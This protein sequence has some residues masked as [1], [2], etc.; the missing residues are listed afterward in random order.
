MGEEEAGGAASRSP[1][2]SVTLDALP[3]ASFACLLDPF[4]VG[5]LRRLAREDRA[6]RRRLGAAWGRAEVA[7]ARRG[8]LA[9][10]TDLR[11]VVLIFARVLRGEGSPRPSVETVYKARQLMRTAVAAAGT[12]EVSGARYD[13]ELLRTQ[14]AS[15]REGGGSAGMSRARVS[16]ALGIVDGAIEARAVRRGE[17]VPVGVLR[18]PPRPAPPRPARRSVPLRVCEALIRTAR[19]AERV[20]LAL[21]LGV[22]LL[23][24]EIARLRREDVR[25]VRASPGLARAVGCR[26]GTPVVWVRA[27]APGRAARWM[28]AP[29]WV[30]RLMQAAPLGAVGS[31]LVASASAPTLA[32]TIRRLRDVVPGAAGLRASDLCRTW[33][34]VALRLGMRREVVRRTW[35]PDAGGHL[36]RRPA[37]RSARDR[38]D[39]PAL[40]D[41]PRLRD[42]RAPAPRGGRSSA[43]AVQVPARSPRAGSSVPQARDRSASGGGAGLREG[44]RAERVRALEQSSARYALGLRPSDRLGTPL[45]R[46]LFSEP[47]PHAYHQP[48]CR[49]PSPAPPRERRARV[50][51]RP[52][53]KTI[54]VAA[55]W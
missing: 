23:P 48:G 29:A 32:A 1:L 10:T 45:L 26:R 24:G 37:S 12:M 47:A 21:A 8:A 54:E 19:P 34:A 33:Q 4:S 20:K 36:A 39:V 13:R 44:V 6:W 43:C 42:E 35:V 7:A 5:G 14:L 25:S 30:V 22:G 52:R 18:A 51:R 17:E 38:V 28:P 53:A 50:F 27:A 41:A 31:P 46:P 40:A 9:D 3:E 2:R 49:R 55:S 16:R 15:P 11:S